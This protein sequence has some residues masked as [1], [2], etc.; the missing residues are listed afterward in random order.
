MIGGIFVDI[1]IVST[2][3]Y[4]PSNYMTGEEIAKVA[5]IALEVV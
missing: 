3:L 5:G 1:G 4:I 2:G